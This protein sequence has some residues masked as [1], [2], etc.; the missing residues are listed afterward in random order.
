MTTRRNFSSGT[1]WEPVAGYSRAVRVEDAVYV[2]GTT[3]TNEQGEIV[4]LGDAHAQ[5]L[6]ALE[7]IRRALERAGARLEDVVRTRM[8]VT[9]MDNAREVA[10]AHGEVFSSI[11]PVT[12]LVQVVGLIDPA[13]LVEIEADAVITE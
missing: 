5:T 1:P 12:A 2:A 6:Q 13:M 11:L 9:D 7:N 10:R 3:A 4:G 8:Y